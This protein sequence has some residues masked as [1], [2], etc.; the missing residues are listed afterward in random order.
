[1]NRIRTGKQNS[2]PLMQYSYFGIV[3][4]NDWKRQ[5]HRSA[6]ALHLPQRRARDDTR[7]SIASEWL[8]NSGQIRTAA[9]T[10]F[11]RITNFIGCPQNR[12]LWRWYRRGESIYIYLA[13]CRGIY[14]YIAFSRGMYICLQFRANF[15]PQKCITFVL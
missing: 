2:L 5:L 14:I 6:R 7:R 1:M 11:S 8:E 3:F 13:F 10:E 9:L 4:W 15:S 12:K